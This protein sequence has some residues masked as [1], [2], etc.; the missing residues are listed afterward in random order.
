MKRYY[1]SIILCCAFF[2]CAQNH[3][4]QVPRP[5][6]IEAAKFFINLPVLET[7]RCILRPLIIE[8]AADIF[9]FLGDVEAIFFT[10][11][12]L[13]SSVDDSIKFVQSILKRY[14][15]AKPSP[16]AIVLKETQKVIGFWG[17]V[18]WQPW[19]G[20]AEWGGGIARRYWGQGLM[21]EAG[22]VILNYGFT[23]LGLNQISATVYPLNV[24]S[25]RLHE[26]LGFKT[27]GLWPEKCYYMDCYWDRYLLVLLKDDYLQRRCSDI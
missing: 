18:N 2:L 27:I 21:S 19:N 3:F 25:L 23:F 4:R 1:C 8:D 7:S 24:L 26:K 12:K 17:F 13:S 5:E 22:E 11:L 9:D 10:P 14:S 15:S 20:S 16:W 6:V